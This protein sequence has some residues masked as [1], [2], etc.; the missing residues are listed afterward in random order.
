MD[1]NS[2]I[3]PKMKKPFLLFALAPVTE[4]EYVEAAK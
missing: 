2:I 1:T 4:A 3:F